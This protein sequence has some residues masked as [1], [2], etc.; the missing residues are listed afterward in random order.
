[1]FSKGYLN[2]QTVKHY[3]SVA[4][5]T[6]N[7]SIRTIQMVEDHCFF[8]ELAPIKKA[9]D[10]NRADYKDTKEYKNTTAYLVDDTCLYAGFVRKC[11]VAS[12]GISPDNVDHWEDAPMFD[13]D[14]LNEL[15]CRAIAPYIAHMVVFT[16]QPMI[17]DS[18]FGGNVGKTQVYYGKPMLEF[19]EKQAYK[20]VEMAYTNLK[21][22][23][24]NNDC[25]GL[26]IKDKPTCETCGDKNNI[27]QQ[28]NDYTDD[29][30]APFDSP[31]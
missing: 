16:D 17:R 22:T 4:S 25:L 3:S 29:N 15:W 18:A 11:K 31:Y 1:M 7:C 13:K 12:V 27:K 9:L 21:K 26:K 30:S 8:N 5:L 14:C 24:D 2:I 20:P 6:S 19:A 28:D 10:D 23:L